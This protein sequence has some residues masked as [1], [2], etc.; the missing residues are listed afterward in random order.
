MKV[1]MIRPER[2]TKPPLTCKQL[3][4]LVEVRVKD[5][6]DFIATLTST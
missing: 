3:K 5:L 6:I 1:W 4:E 2:P